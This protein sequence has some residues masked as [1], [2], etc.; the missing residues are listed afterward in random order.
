MPD[1]PGGTDAEEEG[2]GRGG[3]GGGRARRAAVRSGEEVL[4]AGR[5]GSRDGIR[6]GGTDGLAGALRGPSGP[7]ARAGGAAHVAASGWM[8]AA[9]AIR[10]VAAEGDF[11]G[12]GR[13]FRRGRCI[14]R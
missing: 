11:L 12:F 6:C 2:G 5:R 8:G 3:D 1:L 10:P 14:Y 9:A 13:K 7:A 4:A